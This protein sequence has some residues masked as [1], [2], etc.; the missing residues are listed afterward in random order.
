MPIL[1]LAWSFPSLHHDA[2]LNR[3]KANTSAVYSSASQ[4]EEAHIS[5][6]SS[7]KKQIITSKKLL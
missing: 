3:G 1:A 2:I 7:V 6:P 5:I 4:K